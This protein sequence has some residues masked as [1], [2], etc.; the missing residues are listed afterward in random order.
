MALIVEVTSRVY[1]SG[2]ADVCRKWRQVGKVE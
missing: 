2:Q 1:G